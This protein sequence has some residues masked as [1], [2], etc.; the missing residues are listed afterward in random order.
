VA[1]PGAADRLLFPDRLTPEM[2]EQVM[3]GEPNSLE[4]ET[5]LSLEFE[6]ARTRSVRE[7]SR[8]R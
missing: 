8:H 2:R 6:G 3:L 1:H 7:T 4:F 5:G